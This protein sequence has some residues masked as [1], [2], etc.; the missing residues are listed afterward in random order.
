[1]LGDFFTCIGNLFSGGG[2]GPPPPTTPMIPSGSR[3][4][5]IG[6]QLVQSN[7]GKTLEEFKEL[8][9]VP[10]TLT[11]YCAAG[12]TTI[13]QNLKNIREITTGRLKGFIR[14]NTELSGGEQGA[15]S[16][17]EKLT[18]QSPNGDFDRV[19][20]QDRREILFRAFSKSGPAKVEVVDQSQKFMEKISFP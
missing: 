8:C 17:F 4:R 18:G 13:G 5:N 6:A 11:V 3:A 19:I 1:M 9:G 15:R 16:I 12:K 10:G 2:G 20:A 7:Y 14:G